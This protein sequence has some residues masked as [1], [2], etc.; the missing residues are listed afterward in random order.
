MP[1]PNGPGGGSNESGGGLLKDLHK[2]LDKRLTPFAD[3]IDLSELIREEEQRPISPVSVPM[4]SAISPNAKMSPFSDSSL[5][6]TGMP[7]S[8]PSKVQAA[9]GYE[10]MSKRLAVPFAQGLEAIVESLSRDWSIHIVVHPQKIRQGVPHACSSVQFL[11]SCYGEA[12]QYGPVAIPWIDF[13]HTLLPFV[14]RL[15]NADAMVAFFGD[16]LNVMA[17]RLQQLPLAEIQCFSERGGFLSCFWPSSLATILEARGPT[18]CQELF[19]DDLCGLLM[20]SPWDRQVLTAAVGARF[21]QAL[22]E[23]GFTRANDTGRHK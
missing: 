6:P 14:E 9:G 19:Q 10:F 18:V 11:W 15:S 21:G 3:S 23:L 20:P 12:S 1:R 4:E 17:A 22:K 7:E 16:D 13:R 8:V 2:H 5:F